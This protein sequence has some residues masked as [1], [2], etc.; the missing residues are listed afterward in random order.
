MTIAPTVTVTRTK[1][2]GDFSFENKW[3]SIEMAKRVAAMIPIKT[4]K[5]NAVFRM[6]PTTRKLSEMTS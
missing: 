4:L 3:I 6:I 5:C 1:N 2:T